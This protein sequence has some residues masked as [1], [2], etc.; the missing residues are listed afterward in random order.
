[1]IKCK[2]CG[3]DMDMVEIEGTTELE[4]LCDEC[5]RKSAA[6]R[7]LHDWDFEGLYWS[8]HEAYPGCDGRMRDDE[9]VPP[10]PASPR[11]HKP[12][13]DYYREFMVENGMLQ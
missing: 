13:A 2:A 7:D 11:K 6:A 4:F 3:N 12:L 1:M 8:K 10:L 9:P 5:K